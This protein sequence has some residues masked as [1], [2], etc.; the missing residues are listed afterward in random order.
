MPRQEVVTD[1]VPS[2]K[3]VTDPSMPRVARAEMATLISAKTPM[4]FAAPTVPA[5]LALLAAAEVP[6]S[7]LVVAGADQAPRGAPTPPPLSIVAEPLPSKP[8]PT[9]PERAVIVSDRMVAEAAEAEPVDLPSKRPFAWYLIAVGA[10][11]LMLASGGALVL[12]K[13]F[14]PAPKLAHEGRPAAVASKPVEARA[15]SAAVAAPADTEA[16]DDVAD[17]LEPL[18]AAKKKPAPARIVKVRPVTA[19]QASRPQPQSAA[20]DFGFLQSDVE[21]PHAELKRPEF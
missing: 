14:Y 18:P 20:D 7:V 17:L 1:P 10:A 21:K 3:T 11:L 5:N 9:D 4:P 8:A 2:L 12:S 19:S 16:L 15:V 13:L 6:G